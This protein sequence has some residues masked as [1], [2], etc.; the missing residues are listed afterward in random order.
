MSGIVPEACPEPAAQPQRATAA[1]KRMTHPMGDPFDAAQPQRAT[2]AKNHKMHHPMGD[3]F[4]GF[5]STLA[6]W[7]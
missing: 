1:K 5:D 3:P 4:D 2:A 6:G 7:F